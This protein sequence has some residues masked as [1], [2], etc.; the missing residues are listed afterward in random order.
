MCVSHL[1]SSVLSFMCLMG[2]IYNY[3]VIIRTWLLSYFMCIYFKSLV[4]PLPSSVL[5]C[6]ESSRGLVLSLYTNYCKSN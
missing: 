3:I 6:V 1:L 2:L 4:N 5:A